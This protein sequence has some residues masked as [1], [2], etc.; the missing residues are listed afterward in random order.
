MKTEFLTTFKPKDIYIKQEILYSGDHRI[1]G[2]FPQLC[3]ASLK[4]KQKPGQL[5]FM[6][7]T[8]TRSGTGSTQKG[9]S[10]G[11]NNIQV[12]LHISFKS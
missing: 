11:S 5:M 7:A 9:K 10:G 6:D 2:R 12:R 1:R 4:E 3:Q 8:M